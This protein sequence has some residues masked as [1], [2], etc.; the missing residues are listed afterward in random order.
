M[1]LVHWGLG[2]LALVLVVVA[3]SAA[4]THYRYGTISW[5]PTGNGNEVLFT[6]GQAWRASAFGNP[7]VGDVIPGEGCISTGES[8][9]QIYLKV[10]ARSVVNDYFSATFV[11]AAGN[12]GIR[13]TYSAPNN[14]G[15]P[16][17][18]SW[19][20][21][22]RISPISSGNLHV[23]NPDQSESLATTVDLT[24]PPNSSPRSTLPPINACPREALCTIPIPAADAEGDAL[25]YRLATAGEAGDGNY[26]PPGAPNAPNQAA[27]D[28]ATG[29]LTWDTRG[30]TVGASDVHTL[31]SIQVAIEDGRAKTPLDFFIEILPEGVSP[32]Y[33][34]TPPTPCGQT[35][36]VAANSSLSF[37]VRAQSDDVA[38]IVSVSHLGLPPGAT[39]PTPTPANPTDGTFTWTPTQAGTYLVVF[40][41]EDDLGYPAPACPVTI[42]VLLHPAPTFTTPTTCG[43]A[44]AV[45][46]V[47]GASLSFPLVANSSNLSRTVTIALAVGPGDLAL[48]SS[49]PGN[50]ASATAA[51]ASPVAG[52]WN[53]TFRATDSGGIRATCIVPLEIS[54]P[55]IADAGPATCVRL[56]QDVA[57]DGSAS[58]MPFDIGAIASYAWTFPDGTTASGPLVTRTFSDPAE[59]G[60]TTTTLTVT[61]TDGLVGTDTI[62]VEVIDGL[63]GRVAMARD[64][65][66]PFQRVSGVVSGRAC[67]GPAAGAAVGI[68]VRYTTGDAA[69]DDLLATLLGE[70]G[71]PLVVWSGAGAL[72]ADGS[73]AFD[74]PF[75]IAE[76]F[77]LPLGLANPISTLLLLQGEYVVE[78]TVELAPDARTEP[79]TSF[80]VVVDRQFPLDEEVSP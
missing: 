17:Q 39:F 37:D 1:R 32:P 55:P 7:A 50:P 2:L 6:G 44:P 28:G 27:I 45:R 12:D 69:R 76:R 71:R 74:V 30:A 48:T 10:N 36:S 5:E 40:A 35:L 49:T 23:N 60:W 8:C 13:W 64:E 4:A 46:G 3:G 24:A 9:V 78:T 67:E 34:V 59:V 73:L 16:W 25:S 14:N 80:R 47:Q 54:G 19:G 43:P 56:G 20:S 70:P 41:A 65:Y 63:D 38:R 58:R 15:Q 42:Q 18:V 29:V 53:A 79:T 11:D 57:F 22:C 51:W 52:R 62:D 77:G 75:S 31:Y 33:W 66:T 21:C 72:G 26:V 68:V 61:S